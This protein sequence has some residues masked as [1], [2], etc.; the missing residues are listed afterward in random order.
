MTVHACASCAHRLCSGTIIHM[1]GISMEHCGCLHGSWSGARRLSRCIMLGML[2]GCRSLVLHDLARCCCR[3]CCAARAMPSDCHLRRAAPWLR[4]AAETE[5]SRWLLP[6]PAEVPAASA[7]G[8]VASGAA[9]LSLALGSNWICMLCGSSQ[10]KRLPSCTDCTTRRAAAH[11][12]WWSGLGCTPMAIASC[13]GCGNA[14][15]R[16]RCG[17]LT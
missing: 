11:G 1:R 2:H 10:V 4:A 8:G 16:Q 5:S 7:A 13:A 6:P 3:C 14:C 15:R 9:S 12:C 17:M